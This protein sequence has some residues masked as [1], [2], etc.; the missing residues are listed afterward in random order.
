MIELKE[1][2]SERWIQA[3]KDAKMQ[4]LTQ[5]LSFFKNEAFW[6]DK[7]WKE[8][9]AKHK[10]IKDKLDEVT[11]D[12]DF[13]QHQLVKSKKINKIL[14]LQ[15]I[16]KGNNESSLDSM[17][18]KD[19]LEYSEKSSKSG[20]IHSIE[21]D[22]VSQM[23]KKSYKGDSNKN[24]LILDMNSESKS[25]NNQ[26]SKSHK[27]NT[28][29]KLSLINDDP[30]VKTRF[31]VSNFIVTVNDDQKVNSIKSQ[32]SKIFGLILTIK[33]AIITLLFYYRLKT[34]FFNLS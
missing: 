29:G 28:S 24:D 16:N 26:F 14:Y 17:F 23:I 34:Y 25:K 2:A 22:M 31:S 13:L 5:E 8:Y 33:V 6:L 3:K 18:K 11:Q 12:R 19:N 30:K 7:L 9:K 4:K 15:A 20:Y 32:Q 10:I 1:K 21:E 27:R